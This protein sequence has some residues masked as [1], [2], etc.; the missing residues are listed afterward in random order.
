VLAQ[1]WT[2]A[3]MEIRDFMPSKVVPDT[4]STV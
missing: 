4:G 3:T 2:L 1:W